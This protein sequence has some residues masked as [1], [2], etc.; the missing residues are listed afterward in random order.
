MLTIDEK[1]LDDPQHVFIIAEASGNHDKEYAK[2]EALTHAAA[3]AGASAIKW[4]TYASEEICTDTPLVFGYDS[5]HDAWLRSLGVTTMRQLF[6]K[7]GLPRKW[8]APLKKLANSLNLTFLSTPFSVEAAHFLVEEISVPALKIASGDITF[9]PL[10]QYAATTGLPILLSTGASTYD[11]IREALRIIHE[12]RGLMEDGFFMKD[13]A[14]LH[15]RCL[16]PCPDGMADLS[17]IGHLSNTF[18]VGA[19]GWSDHTLSTEVVPALAVAQGATVIEKHLKLEGDDSSVDA[20]H[21]LT[22]S[23][24]SRMVEIIQRVPWILGNGQKTPI[25]GELHERLWCRRDPRDWLRPTRLA[26][27]GV[28]E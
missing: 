15:C 20:G 4:Q 17:V 28:W 18:P 9:T 24:F 14:V 8:H 10:I 22:P 27:E 2:A 25:G 23:Q 5:A 3:K 16:Y 26:R 21:S 6:R 12:A 1:P 11:E 19:I 7:G 13:V